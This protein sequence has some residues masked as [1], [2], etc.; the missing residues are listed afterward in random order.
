MRHN[1]ARDHFVTLLRRFPICPVVRELQ[2]ASETAGLVVQ[3][4][5]RRDAIVRSAD[6][7]QAAGNQ[8]IDRVAVTYRT[9]CECCDFAK[10]KEPLIEAEAHVRTS[11]LPRLGDM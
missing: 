5:D 2:E 9:Q 3:P 8:R 7:G 4:F 11:L 1:V 10:I 6:Y